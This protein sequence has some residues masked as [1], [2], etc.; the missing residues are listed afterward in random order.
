[1]SRRSR[2][3]RT[4]ARAAPAPAP[5][6]TSRMRTLLWVLAFTTVLFVAHQ[7]WRVYN[8]SAKSQTPTA[9]PITGMAPVQQEH[10]AAPGTPAQVVA[11]E[12]GM[13]EVQFDDEGEVDLATMQRMLDILYKRPNNPEGFESVGGDASAYR[14]RKAKNATSD[15]SDAS[16]SATSSV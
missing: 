11:N 16:P 6:R 2:V 3:Q 7:V 5:E 14:F 12:E 1:M 13:L 8:A 10:P 4:P 15:H 9:G